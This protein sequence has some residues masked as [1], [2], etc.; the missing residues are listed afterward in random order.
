M[1]MEI[2]GEGEEI[3]VAE[4]RGENMDKLLRRNIKTIR[5]MVQYQDMQTLYTCALKEIQTKF[6][7]LNTEFNVMYKRNPINSISTRLKSTESLIRKM[8]N[9]NLPVTLESIKNNINDVAGIRVVCSYIDDIY[10]IADA[11]L[12]QDDIELVAKKDY[13]N[14]PKPN[15]YRSL[16]LIVR[17]PVY[18]AEKRNVVTVEVQIRTI[19]MDFWASLEHQIKYKQSIPDQEETVQRL[20]E[21]ADVIAKTDAEMLNLRRKIEAAENAPSEEEQLMERLRKIDL[22]II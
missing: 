17:T 14:T 16:H 4:G 10:H 3:Y 5:S 9:R 22:R 7:V 1:S 19:A 6:D 15:G 8:L 18:F 2:Y 21:C 13:I 11:L 20:K 12:K